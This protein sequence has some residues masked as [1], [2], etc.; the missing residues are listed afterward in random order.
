MI[1]LDTD[2]THDYHF[3]NQDGVLGNRDYNLSQAIDIA[4]D[5]LTTLDGIVPIESEVAAH[6]CIYLGINYDLVDNSDCNCFHNRD[7]PG[8]WENSAL[9]PV[10]QL[11]VQ[12]AHKLLVVELQPLPHA[13]ALVTLT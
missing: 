4:A 6:N 5:Y 1:D 2:Y 12:V 13:G 9:A 7:F 3:D 8:S 11:A 10:E